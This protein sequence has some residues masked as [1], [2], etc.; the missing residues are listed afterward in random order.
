ML[1]III[2]VA[3][4]VSDIIKEDQQGGVTSLPPTHTPRLGFREQFWSHQ[5]SELCLNLS[6]YN[7]LYINVPL[8]ITLALGILDL[9]IGKR[10]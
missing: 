10:S 6:I 8:S 5:T 7:S 3:F 4:S 1:Q 9:L 2:V